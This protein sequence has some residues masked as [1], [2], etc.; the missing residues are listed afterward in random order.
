MAVHIATTVSLWAFTQQSI[1]VF[2]AAS[3]G[4]VS[5]TSFLLQL[6]Y[7]LA[8]FQMALTSCLYSLWHLLVVL[9]TNFLKKVKMFFSWIN[10]KE[11]MVQKNR[12]TNILT[13]KQ[14]ILIKRLVYHC[15]TYKIFACLYADEAF[16]AWRYI[17]DK[18]L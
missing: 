11:I 8:I 1:L 6:Y 5:I 12:K 2:L 3:G 16:F 13:L 15:I 10:N 14:F 7:Q 9:V 18:V 4:H 17:S